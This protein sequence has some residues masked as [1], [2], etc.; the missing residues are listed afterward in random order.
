MDISQYDYQSR[1]IGHWVVF[2]LSPLK[3]KLPKT[4]VFKFLNGHYCLVNT[5]E[6]IDK[7]IW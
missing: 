5:Q 6:W 3:I 2:I 1:A 7:I 4:L